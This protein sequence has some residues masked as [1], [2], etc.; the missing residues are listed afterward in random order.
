MACTCVCR[1]S[2]EPGP[3]I[4]ENKSSRSAGMRPTDRLEIH[5]VKGGLSAHLEKDSLVAVQIAKIT[6]VKAGHPLSRSAFVAG[7]K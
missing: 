4:P 5:P 1:D 2:E 6:A 7:P 3:P